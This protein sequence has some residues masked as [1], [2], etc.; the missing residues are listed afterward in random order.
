MAAASPVLLILG[1]GPK[2]G[3]SVAKKFLNNG[4]RVATASRSKQT[5]QENDNELS[6]KLDLSKPQDI[7]AVF[8]KVKETFGVAPSV[9]VHNSEYIHEKAC[10]IDHLRRFGTSWIQREPIFK[11]AARPL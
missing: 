7:P 4:Y 5:Q 6:I 10:T 11:C 9:V 2:V 3:A 1:S 8:V